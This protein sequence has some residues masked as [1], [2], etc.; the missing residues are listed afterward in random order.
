M[1][2]VPD[3]GLSGSPAPP[4]DDDARPATAGDL[5]RLRLWLIVAGV[6]AAA[7]TALAVIALLD[8]GD[9]EEQRATAAE[10]SSR[11]TRLE[12]ELKD[13][14]DQVKSDVEALP[15]TEDLS[16]IDRRLKEVEDDASQAARNAK[17]ADEKTGDL[18]ERLGQLEE[19]GGQNTTTTPSPSR[20]PV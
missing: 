19:A 17:S 6:W 3:S 16:K 14:L 7:A 12:Q 8:K 1:G 10:V 20:P 9:E 13:E 4:Q 11:V 15:G 5:K 18:E 2:A